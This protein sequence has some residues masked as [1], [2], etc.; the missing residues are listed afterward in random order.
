MDALADKVGEFVSVLANAGDAH[1]AGPVVIEVRELVRELLD[2]VGRPTGS[3]LDHVVGGWVHRS[4]AHRLG[5]EVEVVTLRKRLKITT[6]IRLTS[7]DANKFRKICT[8]HMV[9]DDR[10]RRRIGGRHG[11]VGAHLEEPGV[12]PLGDDDVGE[13]QRNHLH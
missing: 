3:V 9:V 1:G 11:R 8:H 6:K 2:D 5:D 10:A 7:V 12:D 13:L 4:L